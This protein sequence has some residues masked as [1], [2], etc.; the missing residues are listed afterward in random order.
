MRFSRFRP[1]LLLPVVAIL[2]ATAILWGG[3]TL[4]KRTRVERIEQDREAERRFGLVLQGRLDELE[5]RY[6]NHLESLAH[7]N[8]NDLFSLRDAI[9]RIVGVRQFSTLDPEGKV[10][11][12]LLSSK[13]TE[14]EASVLLPV[15]DRDDLPV[16]R[17]LAFLIE[18]RNSLGG[19]ETG[20]FGWIGSGEDLFYFT[21]L[22]ERR[23][24][25][26]LIDRAVVIASIREWLDDSL[27]SEIA[28]SRHGEGTL[29]VSL[30]G[31]VTAS[32]GEA[33]G[34]EPDVIQQLG[35]R[36]GNWQVRSRDPRRIITEYNSGILAG[37]GLLALLVALAGGVSFFYLNRA[38]CLAERRVSFVNHVTHELKTPL[39]NILLNADLAVDGASPAGVKRLA[40]VQEEAKRLSRLI[41]NVLNYSQRQGAPPEL[42]LRP[43]D[44]SPLVDEV[45]AQFR[46]S[47]ERRGIS[48][49]IT[50]GA[51]A[52]AVVNGDAFA[53]ILGNLISNVEKYASAGGLAHIEKE[54]SGSDVVIRVGDAGPGIPRHER[55][56]IFRPFYRINDSIAEGASGTGLGLSI[57]RD[58]A[59]RMGGSLRV[60]TGSKGSGAIFELRLPAAVEEKVI[61]FPDSRAS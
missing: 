18:D 43:A 55:E 36:F 2:I 56:H 12:H 1:L 13:V 15:F 24:V 50:G 17:R 41:D 61:S 31:I 28:S 48:I 29:A 47:L 33:S 4:S 14:D 34:E 32:L 3:L 26:L 35:S 5:A 42:R 22:S 23:T 58:L 25:L 39:T 8:L 6:R 19:G 27:Q 30:D 11:L 44:L 59:E 54:N 38:L 45:V 51:P 16:G 37:T 20:V 7:E 60:L 49:T 40:M 9:D 52:T 57:A 10:D 53:Q 46:P 21:N